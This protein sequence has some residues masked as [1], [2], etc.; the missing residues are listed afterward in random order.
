MRYAYISG[1]P[2]ISVMLATILFLMLTILPS[3]THPELSGCITTFTVRNIGCKL[4]CSNGHLDRSRWVQRYPERLLCTAGPPTSSQ[5]QHA[6]MHFSSQI[7]HPYPHMVFLLIKY[8][9]QGWISPLWARSN[10][11]V[12]GWGHRSCSDWIRWRAKKQRWEGTAHKLRLEGY[13]SMR[14]GLHINFDL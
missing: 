9:W 10:V 8:F 1:L 14:E 6:P 5:G 12:K 2:D 4:L 7:P 13:D 3:P 11:K